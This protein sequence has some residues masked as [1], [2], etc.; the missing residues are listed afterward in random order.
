MVIC[1]HT[2]RSFRRSASLMLFVLAVVLM[3]WEGHRL[4]AAVVEGDIPQESIRLR[5]LANSDSPQDQLVKRQVRDAVVARMASWAPELHSLTEARAVIAARLPELEQAVQDELQARGIQY[6]Y[7]VELG[8]V[9]FPTKIYGNTVYPAG[10]YE[11]LRITLGSGEGQ[12]WWC[13]L[14]PPLCF[15]DGVSGEATASAAAG[16]SEAAA[17]SDTQPD[18]EDA[19]GSGGAQV[20]AAGD[21]AAAP[22][23][24]VKFFLWEI[25]K[26]MLQ[27][28]KELFS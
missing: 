9:P 23:A 22:K 12:N 8:M 10:D 20:R 5:V 1:N 24:E 19:A 4:D 26:S 21:A 15:V 18:K 14:F 25:I 7:S 16:G 27:F 17:G 2:R 3:S 6:G 13:V 11:A 28:I